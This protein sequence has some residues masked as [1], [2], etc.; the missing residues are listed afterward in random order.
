M[1]E[2]WVID[3]G[4]TAPVPPEAV[5]ERLRARA[6]DGW[7]ETWLTSSSG[8]LLGFVTNTERAMVVLLEAEGDAGEHAVDPGAG[9]SSGGF[10]LSNGQH[11][12]YPDEDT[13]PLDEAFRIVRHIVGEGSWPVDA[14]RVA[15]R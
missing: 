12:E 8:R 5:P 3:D 14:P 11:D 1:I 10:V 4:G 9:G 13:V 2:S 6:G 15:D 7:F